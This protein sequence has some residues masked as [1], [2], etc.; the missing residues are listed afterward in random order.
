MAFSCLEA[1]QYP[2]LVLEAI[3]YPKYINVA[4]AMVEFWK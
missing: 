4:H 2:I 1:I 3:R